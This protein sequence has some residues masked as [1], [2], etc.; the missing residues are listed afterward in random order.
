MGIIKFINT[1]SDGI[2]ECGSVIIEKDDVEITLHTEEFNNGKGVHTFRVFLSNM[3]DKKI[4]NLNVTED[5]EVM[6][7]SFIDTVY[8]YY[9]SGVYFMG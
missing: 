6:D 4:L 7:D 5:Y 8:E 2:T 3:E 9:Q 1:K